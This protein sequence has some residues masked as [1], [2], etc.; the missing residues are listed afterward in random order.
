[1]GGGDLCGGGQPGRGAPGATNRYGVD[2]DVAILDC[3]AVSLMTYP[4][5]F[6]S[7]S[8]WPAAGGNRP[9]R[10]GALDRADERRLLRLH[11]QQRPTVPGL[12]RH[13]RAPGPARRSRPGAGGQAL[14]PARR[15]PRHRARTYPQPHHGRRC[16]RRQASFRLPAAPVL[17]APGVLAFEHFAREAS[18]NPRRPDASSSLVSPIASRGARHGRRGPRPGSEHTTARRGRHTTGRTAT[19]RRPHTRGSPSKGCGSWTARPGGPD[20]RP[21][22]PWRRSV[23][24]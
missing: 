9:H 3:M 4:S 7:F 6:A 23:P 19:P 10:P 13:D 22:T 16:W 12:A 5:L 8:G 2:V 15:V 24:T 1:M 21:P 20:R 18:S 11:R 14:R 17:D